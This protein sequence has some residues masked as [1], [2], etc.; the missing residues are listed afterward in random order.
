[1]VPT[2]SSSILS[3]GSGVGVGVAVLVVS[4]PLLTQQCSHAGLVTH[5]N[6]S[7]LFLS[8]MRE[9]SHGPP[10]QQLSGG[11]RVLVVVA[12][13]DV[14][15]TNMLR[16]AVT[17]LVIVLVRRVVRVVVL[18]LVERGAWARLQCTQLQ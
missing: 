8:A 17:A 16:G 10:I 11:V 2:G 15:V 7:S 6:H 18:V 4:V 9:Q 14:G 3:E 12:D 5:W 13:A 1:M